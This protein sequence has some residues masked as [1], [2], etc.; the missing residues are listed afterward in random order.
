[1]IKGD[2]REAVKVLPDGTQKTFRI[3]ASKSGTEY[4]MMNRLGQGGVAKV[5]RVVSLADHKEYAFKVFEYSEDAEVRYEHN[6]IRS[7]IESLIRKAASDTEDLFCYL[8]RPYEI[9]ELTASKGFGYIMELVKLDDMMKFSVMMKRAQPDRLISLRICKNMAAFYAR[10]HRGYGLCYKD[11]NRGNIFVNPKTGDIRIIDLD[12][13]SVP[14]TNT[15]IG[16]YG[17]I[18]PEV[19]DNGK[20]D[21]YSDYFSEASFFFFLLCMGAFPLIGKRVLEYSRTNHANLND[22][23]VQKEVFGTNALFIFDS[24]SEENTIRGLSEYQGQVKLWDDMPEI[25]KN[26]FIRTFT[27]GLHDPY[28]RVSDKNWEKI[29]GEIEEKGLVQCRCGKYNFGVQAGRKNCIYCNR[30]IRKLPSPKTP[31]PKKESSGISVSFDVM[32][33]MDPAHTNVTLSA[34]QPLIKDIHPMLKGELLSVR[35]NKKKQLIGAVNTSPVRW[36]VY[37]RNHNKKYVQPGE[38]AIL[39]KGTIIVVMYRK[40]QLS[41]QEIKMN[42]VA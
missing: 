22:Y 8:A 3:I 17:F 10:L 13:I 32:R 2:Y 38:T 18:A 42:G 30:P 19:Y 7:N 41:V 9:V 33:N 14:Q 35:V 37:D 40:L 24:D 6:N 28:Q 29:F 31:K 34:S 27:A 20:P 5:F 12:N 1:M 39:E 15:I 36:S 16:T 21:Y 26:A 23:N 4:V 25:L 11:L